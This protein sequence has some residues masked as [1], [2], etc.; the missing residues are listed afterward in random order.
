M[1]SSGGVQI[2]NTI[3]SHIWLKQVPRPMKSHWEQQSSCSFLLLFPWPPVTEFIAGSLSSGSVSS[4]A[5]LRHPLPVVQIVPSGMEKWLLL[6]TAWSN[7][8]CD[9]SPRDKV[10]ILRAEDGS[11]GLCVPLQAVPT[12][13]LLP[14]TSCWE[15]TKLCTHMLCM[16]LSCRPVHACPVQ[17]LPAELAGWTRVSDVTDL[18]VTSGMLCTTRSLASEQVTLIS[19]AGWRA[20]NFLVSRF[21]W[22]LH[23]PGKLTWQLQEPEQNTRPQ[24]LK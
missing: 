20:N 11:L 21:A 4:A 22:K 3:I 1:H 16:F 15:L 5:Y 24:N 19:S 9:I 2:P 13:D 14:S 7:L 6:L 12:D 8:R 18:L 10:S 17:P 23:I